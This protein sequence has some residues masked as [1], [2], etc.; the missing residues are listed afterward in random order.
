MEQLGKKM[1]YAPD[2]HGRS[3]S[4]VDKHCSITSN[5]QT[6][7]APPLPK[8]LR[9]ARLRRQLSQTKLGVAAGIDIVSA[10]S[11]LNQYERGRR[12]PDFRTVERLA[13]VLGFPVSFFFIRED[14]LA[15]LMLAIHEMPKHLR[16]QLLNQLQS[17]RPGRDEG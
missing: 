10:S 12:S 7:A 9:Q 8:R 11:R 13:K 14:D 1:V 17:D 6:D 3:Q 15:E 4:R 16:H 5:H 2:Q